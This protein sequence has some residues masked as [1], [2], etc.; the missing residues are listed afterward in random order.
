MKNLKKLV[1]G[2]KDFLNK[3]FPDHQERYHELAVSGQ[4]PKIMVIGCSDSRV[5]PDLIFN[6][7]P[8][9]MFV[10]RNVANLVPPFEPDDHYHGTS[11]GIEFAVTGLNIRHIVIM[12]HS[13]CGGVQACCNQVEGNPSGSLFIDKWTSIL[14]DCARKVLNENPD[15][16]PEDLR[17]KVEQAA[18]LASLENLRSFP[19]VQERITDG[20]L[21]IHGAYFDVQS[22]QLYALDQETNT[23]LAVE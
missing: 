4:S 7:K 3:D 16:A 23:F 14:K 11:A 13:L 19:F 15:L 12:G 20:S 9:E 5:N 22:A 17:V 2:Y 6:T 8:G 21:Q 1:S 18:I 10:I